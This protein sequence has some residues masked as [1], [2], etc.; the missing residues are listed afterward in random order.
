MATVPIPDFPPEVEQS[1]SNLVDLI[2]AAKER[3]GEADVSALECEIDHLVYELYGLT[4][5]EIQIVEG[6]AK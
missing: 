5:E 2:L 6:S 4:P 1:L 3:D